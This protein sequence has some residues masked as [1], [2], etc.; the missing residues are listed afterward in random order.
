MLILLVVWDYPL[1]PLTMD[2]NVILSTNFLINLSPL[3]P[4]TTTYIGGQ[5]LYV[6]EKWLNYAASLQIS[7]GVDWGRI[8]RIAGRAFCS[9]LRLKVCWYKET[10]RKRGFPEKD[11]FQDIND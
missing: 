8:L 10:E 7:L 11:P 4:F 9:I 6:Y 5:G 3:P 1:L 2:R